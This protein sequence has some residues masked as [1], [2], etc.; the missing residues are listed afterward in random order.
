MS[1]GL[2]F[3]LI[4]LA[5]WW[6]WPASTKT[7][8]AQE[9]KVVEPQTRNEDRHISPRP[10]SGAPTTVGQIQVTKTSKKLDE[11]DFAGPQ[12][13]VHFKV[14]DGLAVAF[15]DQI[16]GVPVGDEPITEGY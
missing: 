9:T 3:I 13:T 7:E 4:G 16:L 6:Y 1:R 2:F 11:E 12:T 14:E 8:I 15:G 10:P 5:I